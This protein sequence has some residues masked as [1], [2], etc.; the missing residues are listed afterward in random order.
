MN[1]HAYDPSPSESLSTPYTPLMR[2]S[3]LAMIS[4]LT[5][6]SPSPPVPTMIWRMPFTGSATP[7]VVC[8]ANRS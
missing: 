8:G 4:V 6:S 3:L 1:C 2:T 7:A 5:A